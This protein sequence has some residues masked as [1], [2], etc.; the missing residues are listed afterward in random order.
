MTS[1]KKSG[2]LSQ[3]VEI[4]FPGNYCQ[5]GSNKLTKIL[6]KKIKGRSQQHTGKNIWQ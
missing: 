6:P 2:A 4:L 3:S 1:G 5:F